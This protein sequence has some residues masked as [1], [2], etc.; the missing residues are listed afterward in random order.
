MDTVMECERCREPEHVKEYL[1]TDYEGDEEQ[2]RTE[3]TDVIQLC[4]PCWDA[5]QDEVC[6]PK[7][8]KG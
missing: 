1:F 7:Y 5:E 4:E 2:G 8:Q 3:V 6:P